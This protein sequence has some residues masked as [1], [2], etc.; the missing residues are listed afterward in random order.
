[1]NKTEWNNLFQANQ[2]TDTPVDD[3]VPSKDMRNRLWFLRHD[4]QLIADVGCGHAGGRALRELGF[5]CQI[6]C[7]DHSMIA[8]NKI[9][10]PKISRLELDVFNSNLPCN[11]YDLAYSTQVIEHTENQQSFMDNLVQSVKFGGYVFVAST[12]QPHHAWYPYRNKYGHGVIHP[13]HVSEY[14]STIDMGLQM[15]NAG[16]KEIRIDVSAL[17][18]AIFDPIITRLPFGAKFFNSKAY[19][20]FRRRTKVPI[21]G[22]KIIQGLGRK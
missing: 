9:A 3:A 7:V 10:T 11:R 20:D 2:I 17:K 21:F 5:Y 16:L 6:E 1:M 22:Y 13:G 18:Y 12:L 15:Q 4:C 19:M 8:L 14:R